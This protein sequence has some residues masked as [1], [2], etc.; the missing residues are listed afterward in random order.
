MRATHGEVE[1]RYPAV[2][3]AH[4]M[5]WYGLLTLALMEA[6]YKAENGEMAWSREDALAVASILQRNGY[7]IFGVD[8]WI[9]TTPGPTPYLHDWSRD[10]SSSGEV[11][12]SAPQ[13]IATFKWDPSHGELRLTEPFFNIWAER[14]RC[15]ASALRSVAACNAP[16]ISRVEI[17]P[18]ADPAVRFRL[19]RRTVPRH[20]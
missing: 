17:E 5:D 16:A 10:R 9:P 12:I 18:I 3:D 11:A 4:L 2:A 1:R 13:F 14:A 6:A 20:P 7:E 15:I 8:V 19:C